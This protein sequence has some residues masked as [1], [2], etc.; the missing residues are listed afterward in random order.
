MDFK[1]LIENPFTDFLSIFFR[2]FYRLEVKGLE[3]FQKAGLNPIIAL[4]HISF[5][6]RRRDP[7]Y[8]A[9][10]ASFCN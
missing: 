4:N 9:N 3:N 5:F 6:R 1:K 7:V 8:F 2:C 10:E